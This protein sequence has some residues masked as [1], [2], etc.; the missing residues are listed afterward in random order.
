VNKDEKKLSSFE[1]V[2]FPQ[3]IFRD[4]YGNP[5]KLVPR[6]LWVNKAVAHVIDALAVSDLS[7]AMVVSDTFRLPSA[8]YIALKKKGPMVAPPGLSGHNYGIS[9]DVAL[10]ATYKATGLSRNLLVPKLAGLGIHSISSEAWHFNLMFS[11]AREYFFS[12]LD[13]FPEESITEIK[14]SLVSKYSKTIEKV[15]S[16]KAL[17]SSL[18]LTPDGV[19]GKRTILA[20][21]MLLAE[22]QGMFKRIADPKA[23]SIVVNF[24]DVW[25]K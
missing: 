18:G 7:G 20:V 12:L 2:R 11:V 17:Q 14:S 4:I 5:D 22:K 8:S 3:G 16:V 1:L 15:K 24:N 25:G 23:K 13:S 6:M 21:S 19:I 9:I 10:D